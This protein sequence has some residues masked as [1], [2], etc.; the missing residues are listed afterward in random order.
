MGR[1][2]I[3]KMS[4]VRLLVGHERARILHF[5]KVHFS[6]IANRSKAYCQQTQRYGNVYKGR[7][8][9]FAYL[10]HLIKYYVFDGNVI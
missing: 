10:L 5:V 6:V 2:T 3:F 1:M 8:P 4:I 7:H 9:G